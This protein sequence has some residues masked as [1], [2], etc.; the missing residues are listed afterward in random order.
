[1]DVTPPID[2]KMR[3]LECYRSQ[4]I[5]GRPTTPRSFLDELRE[6]ARYWGWTIGTGYG[7]PFASREEI[8]LRDLRDLTV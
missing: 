8:G 3:A 7:E 6:R 4:F 5:E 2:A 1:M